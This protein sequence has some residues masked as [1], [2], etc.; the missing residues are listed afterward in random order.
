M[1]VKK[2]YL[3]LFL[4]KDIYDKIE[5]PKGMVPCFGDTNYYCYDLVVGIE[6]LDYPNYFKSGDIEEILN[7]LKSL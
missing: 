6:D 1:V 5:L 2:T 7:K 4:D 3:I